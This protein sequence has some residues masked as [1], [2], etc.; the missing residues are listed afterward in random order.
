M[1]VRVKGER[2]GEKNS[3]E[4]FNFRSPPPC[5]GCLLGGYVQEERERRRREKKGVVDT[6]AEKRMK[7]RGKC[8]GY[9]SRSFL[10]L[11]LRDSPFPSF[12]L[13]TGF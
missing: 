2:K 7:K 12:L 1:A 9:W 8:G 3:I 6:A 5:Q 10:S 13:H 11:P 4:T